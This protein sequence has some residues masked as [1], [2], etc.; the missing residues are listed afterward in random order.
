[1]APTRPAEVVV[2][3]GS[4]LGRGHVIDRT[5]RPA[6]RNGPGERVGRARA[7]ARPLDPGRPRARD[8]G[9]RARLPATLGARDG[10]GRRPGV[11]SDRRGP[12][13]PDRARPRPAGGD[14]AVAGADRSRSS[15]RCVDRASD[16]HRA[17]YLEL[18]RRSV[19]RPFAH[20]CCCAARSDSR[21]TDDP[22]RWRAGQRLSAPTAPRTETDGDGGG[23]R[24]ESRRGRPGSRSDGAQHGDGRE[25]GAARTPPSE[26]R[27]VAHPSIRATTK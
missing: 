2:S 27:G 12:H 1:M 16:A 5:P 10:Q 24:T 22:A 15:N 17:R 21:R 11:R 18:A 20:R 13:R 25:R 19:A 6:F 23:V 26:H 7:M 9:R 4:Q 14:G 3:M 8:V